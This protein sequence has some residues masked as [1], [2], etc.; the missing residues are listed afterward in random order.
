ME[1][2]MLNI[3]TLC[4]APSDS[5]GSPSVTSGTTLVAPANAIDTDISLASQVAEGAAA[6]FGQPEISAGVSA[7]AAAAT[8]AENDVAAHK[9]AV[10]AALDSVTAALTTAPAVLATMPAETQAKISSGLNAA[11][12]FLSWLLQ[13]I[14]KI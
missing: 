11:S 8:A 5:G 10:A 4:S 9:T 6:A 13:E 12:G 7:A 1:T 2:D 14:E 3:R